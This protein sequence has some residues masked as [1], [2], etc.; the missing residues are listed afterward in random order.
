MPSPQVA[1]PLVLQLQRVRNVALPPSAPPTATPSRRLLRLQLTDGHTHVGAVEVEGEMEGVGPLMPP[2][3]KLR[4][5]G[6]VTVQNHFLLLG[7]SSL[8]VMGG[9]VEALRRKWTLQTVSAGVHMQP[10]RVS[11][12]HVL[13]LIPPCCQ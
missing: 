9:S 8:V 3:T 1:G 4:L 6:R 7:R 13:S 2:G 12:E 10:G 11:Q 5:S